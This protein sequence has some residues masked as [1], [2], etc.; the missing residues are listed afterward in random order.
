MDSGLWWLLLAGLAVVLVAV[1]TAWRVT[2]SATR[3]RRRLADELAASRE[4][5]AAV[6]RRLDGLARRVEVR[7]NDDTAC[8]LSSFRDAIGVGSDQG[9]HPPGV[10]PGGLAH[11]TVPLPYEPHTVKETEAPCRV[12]RRVLPERV[13]GH[14][15]W[16]DPSLPQSVE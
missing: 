13:A 8:L 3:A 11:Q 5:L 2:V 7:R 9:Y 1:L 6:Q 14:H 12:G 10:L 16:Q 4:E 15:A